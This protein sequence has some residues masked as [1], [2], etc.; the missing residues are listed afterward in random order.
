[1][2]HAKSAFAQKTLNAVNAELHRI[3]TERKKKKKN[4]WWTQMFLNVHKYYAIQS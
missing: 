4:H 1:M 2:L 3:C